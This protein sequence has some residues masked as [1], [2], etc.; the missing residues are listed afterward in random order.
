MFRPYFGHHQ[1]YFVQDIVTSLFTHSL[2]INVE[3]YAVYNTWQ[4]PTAKNTITVSSS[5]ELS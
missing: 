2:G 5:F 4:S 3:H 1:G